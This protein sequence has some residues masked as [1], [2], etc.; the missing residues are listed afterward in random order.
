MSII[1]NWEI[2]NISN[3]IDVSDNANNI[4]YAF[5]IN[6]VILEKRGE[7]QV[8][9]NVISENIILDLNV[10]EVS[11]PLSIDSDDLIANLQS[12]LFSTTVSSS[13]K[14]FENTET[15]PPFKRTTSL[16][17]KANCTISSLILFCGVLKP[18]RH[19]LPT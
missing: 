15:S 2:S 12:I 6:G 19:C 3:S 4:H 11:I 16:P 10:N 17:S 14:I 5:P 9:L 7:N 13:S 8:R 18:R 1:Y